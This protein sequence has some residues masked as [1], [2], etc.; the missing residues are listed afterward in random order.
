MGSGFTVRIGGAAGDG[1][2]S[3]GE[4][5]AR[6]C[7]RSG[8]HLFAY[9]SYQ[10]VIRGGHVWFQVRASD[11]G[12]VESLGEKLDLL[13]ALNEETA[14]YW[15]PLIRPGGGLLYDR[16]AFKPELPPRVRDLGM[17]LA[18]TA[19]KF[20]E[21]TILRNTVALGATVH[22]LGLRLQT[23]EEMVEQTFHHKGR[24]VIGSNTGAIR[25]GHGFARQNFP[26]PLAR[27]RLDP[28]KR[29]P[30]LTGNQAVGLGALAGGCK[31]YAAYPMTPAS[32]VLHY[33][34]V[35]GPPHGMVVK[36]AEDELAVVNMA[37]GAG[38]AGARALCGTSGGGFAL[39]TEAVGMAGMAEVPV[40]IFE[41]Q[42]GGPSTGLPC[43][44]EQGDLNQVLGASQGDYPRCVIAP[45]DVADAYRATV[46]A[47][48]I[49]DR[50]QM[51][52]I[53]MSDFYLSE[54]Y[55]TLDGLDF[56][57]PVERGEFAREGGGD[58]KRYRFTDSGVSPRV[59][60]GTPEKMFVAGTDEHDESG[61]LLSDVLSGLPGHVETRAKM[62]EKRMRKVETLLRE[63]PPPK[64]EGPSRADATL[65]CWGSTLGTLREALGLLREAGIPANLLHL[66]Y[67]V[68]FHG[69]EVAAILGKAK[70]TV[71]VENNYSGQ[72]E[73][74]LRAETGVAVDGRVRKWDGE[75]FIAEEVAA[76]VGAV[77]E[78]VG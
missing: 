72:M 47:L 36:Q 44:T 3:A 29:R 46:E 13:V 1:I 59:L 40:V 45:G 32:T 7:S 64:L 57:V 61:N 41:S 60:P 49:A 6:V 9:N 20:S 62:M 42:R 19:R 39:M 65:V 5:L 78:E 38:F 37:I 75:P 25:E 69:K 77:L 28:G 16:G 10:S 50:Y 74:H 34:S 12:P 68:P 67:V 76:R 48:N 58:F 26:E 30:L 14:A 11:A 27:P 24:E 71:M 56:P 33:L 23:L 52:V 4:S 22:L 55:R 70:T 73:R 43:K 31:F 54:H 17:D 51:P 18:E 53:V 21:D 35:K 63:L 66:R 2:A 8:L 15:L